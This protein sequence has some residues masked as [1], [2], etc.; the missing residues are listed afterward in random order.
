MSPLSTTTKYKIVDYDFIGGECPSL[1][2]SP[3]PSPQLEGIL[4]RA[5]DKTGHCAE[6]FSIEAPAINGTDYP[7]LGHGDVDKKPFRSNIGAAMQMP[8]NNIEYS[9]SRTSSM[10]I[11]TASRNQSRTRDIPHLDML[12]TSLAAEYLESATTKTKKRRKKRNN[13]KRNNDRALHSMMDSAPIPSI[14]GDESDFSNHRFPKRDISLRGSLANSPFLRPTSRTS[15]ITI[16]ISALRQQIDTLNLAQTSSCTASVRSLIESRPKSSDDSRITSGYQSLAEDEGLRLESYEVPFNEEF[17]SK[18]IATE[19]M[20]ALSS[21]LMCINDVHRRMSANDFDVLT[22][23]GKGSFGTVHLVKQKATG[24]LFAQKMFRKASITIRKTLIE[25]T[26]T[27]RAILENIN[28]HPFIVNLYYAFQDHEK[29]YLILEYA[30][31]GELFTH[32]AA[33]HMFP[34]E[35]ASFYMAEIIVALNYLHETGIV[36]RDLKPENCLLDAEGHL[37]L[38]DFGLSKEVADEEADKCNSILGTWEYMAPEV[39][40]GKFY[41]K[42]VDWWSLGAVAFDLLTGNPPFTGN[43]NAKIQEK[44]L[45]AKLTFPYFLTPDAKDLLTRL[46]RRDPR[47]RLGSNMPKDLQTLKTHRFFRKIDWR[48]L[49]SR[50]LEPPIRPVVTDPAL[51]ENFSPE[52]TQLALSPRIDGAGMAPW[53]TVD[54]PVNPFGGFSF[55]ASKSLFSSEGFLAMA[56]HMEDHEQID[57]EETERQLI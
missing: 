19:E 2:T 50:E 10:L 26:K 40:E 46:L 55:V 51:A 57:N 12:N 20:S 9:M 6:G 21:T 11:S 56:M 14:S 32:L 1:G 53:N 17:I 24:K 3:E 4:E 49:E 5:G 34:E 37:L 8:T 23:L 16:G 44:I 38:T 22:C 54:E 15:S 33:E 25:Q 28:R 29:L 18:A 35:T 42:A 39:I 36:Y 31:G 13:Q 27:E 47:K 45:R 48:K 43:N 41:D 52:F 30:Q 7:A